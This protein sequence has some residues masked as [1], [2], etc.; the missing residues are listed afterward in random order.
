MA[1]GAQDLVIFMS[2]FH[3]QTLRLTLAVAP[4]P[5]ARPGFPARAAAAPGRDRRPCPVGWHWHWALLAGGEASVI[6]PLAG[7]AES[8]SE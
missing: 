1:S 3:W 7:P 4:G 5:D 8:Y 6:N 2:F